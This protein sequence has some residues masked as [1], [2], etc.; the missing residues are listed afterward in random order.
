MQGR[1]NG[2]FRKGNK[3]VKMKEGEKR[4]DIVSFLEPL[5]LSVLIVVCIVMKKCE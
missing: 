2:S 3:N 5:L 4:M 1:L